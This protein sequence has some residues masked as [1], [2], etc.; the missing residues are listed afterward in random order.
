MLGSEV[1]EINDTVHALRILVDKKDTKIDNAK[2]IWL[3]SN[4]EY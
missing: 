4:L 2:S 3:E 1:I